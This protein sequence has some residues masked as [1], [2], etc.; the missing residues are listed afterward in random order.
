MSLA[1]RARFEPL[2]TLGFAAIGAAYMGVGTALGNPI[3]QFF[4]QNMTDATLVF[5]F[6]G[7]ND[8]FELPKNGYWVE[9]VTANKVNS[10]GLFFAEGDRLYVRQDTVAPTLGKV[11]FSAIYGSD[12]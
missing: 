6:D 11:S 2:R 4:V 8:H 10:Q 5:S 1:I 3:R 12:D 9:D 7:I